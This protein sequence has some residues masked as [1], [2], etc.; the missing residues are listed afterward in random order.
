MRRPFVAVGA[1]LALVGFFL[2]FITSPTL[3]GEAIRPTGADLGGG[4]WLVFAG[5]LTIFGCQFAFTDPVRDREYRT[6]VVLAAVAGLAPMV[7]GVLSLSSKKNLLGI[8]ASDLGIKPAIGAWVSAGGLLLSIVAALASETKALAAPRPELPQSPA[9]VPPTLG[10][11]AEISDPFGSQ[12]FLGPY[13]RSALAESPRAVIS[14][15]REGLRSVHVWAIENNVGGLLRSHVRS[16]ATVLTFVLIATA[17]YYRFL[18]AHPTQDGAAVAIAFT[19]CRDLY[20][21]QVSTVSAQFSSEL[22]QGSYHSRSQAQGHLQSLLQGI[23]PTYERCLQTADEDYASRMKRYTAPNDLSL[24]VSSFSEAGGSRLE[25]SAIEEANSS[26]SA[27][28]TQ[29][30]SIRARLPDSASI[31]GNLIGKS[32]DGWRF[33][34]GSEITRVEILAKHEDGESL[35]LRTRISLSDYVTKQPYY[36]VLDLVYR[37]AEDGQWNFD[38]FRELIFDRAGTDYLAGADIFLVGNWRWSDSSVRYDADG[39][40]SGRWDNGQVAS[41]DWRIVYGRLVQT[42]DGRPMLTLPIV[43]FSKDEI[44]VG[45]NPP[46]RAERTEPH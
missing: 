10:T 40:W 43:S 27:A 24:F 23:R 19:T 46:Q 21:K 2:P 17:A 29:I 30:S 1:G 42:Q 22:T 12:P 32:M 34:Y 35:T 4:L 9:F 41:G 16:I 11:R 45:G 7:L 8:S 6:A 38:S 44:V 36:G 13:L 28:L 25:A 20:D 14:A 18:K 31:V 5:G 39:T 33:S 26:S 15:M 3:F 37:L